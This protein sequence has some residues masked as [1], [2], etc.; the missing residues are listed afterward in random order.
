MPAIVTPLSVA[1]VD[2]FRDGDEGV[3]EQLVRTR[4]DAMVERAGMQLGADA[5]AAP[6][7]AMSVLMGAWT[8]RERFLTPEA[9]D[10]YLD[11][12]LPHRCAE[13]MRRRASLHRFEKHEG[14][15]VTASTAK[16]AMTAAEAW[17]EIEKR[18][19]VS[20][21]ELAEHREESR[22][23]ARRHARENVDRVATRRFPVGMVVIGSILLA[24]AVFAMRW[25]DQ[26]SAE[27]AL[28]K[29]I[30]SDDARV[31]QASPGQRG[32]ITLLD[33]ST[34]Q[35]GAGSMM[36]IPRGFGASV[37]GLK[38]D[39]AGHFVVAQ[40]QPLPFQVRVR[41]SAVTAAGT[42]FSVRAYDDEPEVLVTV[43]E[44]SVRVHPVLG[45]NASHVIAAGE[46]IAIANDGTVRTPTSQELALL[47][48]WV[49][50]E[51][52]LENVTVDRAIAKLK[53]W[54]NLD[55][56]LADPKLGERLVN[57]RLTLESSGQALD[58]L[59]GAAGLTMDYKGEQMVLRDASS[60]PAN[61]RK[62]N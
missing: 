17:D 45:E 44:G 50:G 33:E 42:D 34:A 26:G 28:S 1:Q 27:L 22:K 18:L 23:L 41:N 13:E 60:L 35:L 29:A 36:R 55:I 62:N 5:P 46:G 11:E 6:R 3:F 47:F 43:R 2:A 39:G 16:S 20:A 21:E 40:G 24:A 31:V 15:Q 19:H 54:H 32:S 25:M 4:Y 48:S 7:V 14:V 59:T 38:L 8:D 37:R 58:A 52:I 61:S 12:Q 51:I 56:E 30:Q 49:D 10:D 53:R 9:M 57:T